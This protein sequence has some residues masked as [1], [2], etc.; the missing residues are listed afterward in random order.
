MKHRVL[1]IVAAALLIVFGATAALA[2]DHENKTSA[3]QAKAANAAKTMKTT[4]A[5]TA[6]HAGCPGMESASAHAGCP[7]MGAAA[8]ASHAECPHG[9]VE[10]A[11]TRMACMS[12]HGAMASAAASCCA[13]GPS[14][15]EGASAVTAEARSTGVTAV[16]AGSS[17][18]SHEKSTMAGAHGDC[19]WCSDMALCDEELRK[20]GIETQ[21]VPL[22]NGVMILYTA[23]SPRGIEAVQASV[24][25]RGE[26]LGAIVAAGDKAHLCPRC[27][28]MRGAMASGK[29]VRETVNIE[30]GCLTVMTSDDPKIVAQI[31]AISGLSNG[32][33][34]T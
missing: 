11:S 7:G 10:T 6:S 15:A 13:A 20:I 2:C 26:R 25:R 22:K 14:G 31:Q 30:G 29:L 1:P 18:G 27:K 34:K 16:P 28:E 12:A 5:V 21:T 23:T 19:D 32:H 8:A 9:A 4:Q 33:T 24:T 17:C 3:A